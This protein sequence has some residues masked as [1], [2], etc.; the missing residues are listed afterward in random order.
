MKI[1]IIGA[2][3]SAASLAYFL[4]HNNSIVVS[5]MGEP[6]G[7]LCSDRFIS[8][9]LVSNYG[10]HIFHTNS[11]QLWKFI[12]EFADWTTYCNQPLL[13]TGDRFI[14]LPITMN[15]FYEVWG[16]MTES[17][18]RKY[19][20]KLNRLE[21]ATA[22]EKI[23]SKKLFDLVFRG[24]TEKQW[25][26]PLEEISGNILSR[27]KLRYN[28]YSD[29][30]FT[31][32]QGLPGNGDSKF[33][34][35]LFS[36][37]KATITDDITIEKAEDFDLTIICSELDKVFGYSLGTIPYYCTKFKETEFNI[38]A[39]IVNNSSKDCSHIRT[40]RY[41]LLYKFCSK[42]KIEISEYPVQES[43]EGVPCYPAANLALYEK[44]ATLAKQRKFFLCGRLAENRYLDMD[45]A[46]ENAY[47]LSKMIQ[48]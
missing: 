27:I 16:V 39:A 36:A 18:V 38:P 2:G 31:D 9:Q 45:T 26:C 1:L 40:T 34:L 46:I 13:N 41:D 12:N 4:R 42:R 19:V 11:S 22:R 35:E 20:A 17:E 29:Y 28:F 21:G 33:I 15:T 30:F 14:H 3:L 5:T 44:Y 25:G 7:G 23:I 8:G 48:Y 43:R 24:Y 47:K 10:P 32:Y 6:V 37:A